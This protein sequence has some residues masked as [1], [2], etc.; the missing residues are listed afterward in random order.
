MRRHGVPSV[1]LLASWWQAAL[2]RLVG[3]RGALTWQALT[4]QALTWQVMTRQA[5]TWQVLARQLLA[6]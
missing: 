4:W 5:L 6:V 1:Y 3:C 2:T